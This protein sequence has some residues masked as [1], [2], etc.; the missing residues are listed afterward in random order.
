MLLAIVA[1]TGR[2]VGIDSTFVARKACGGHRGDWGT[3]RVESRRVIATRHMVVKIHM[4][5]E[6]W[7]GTWEDLTRLQFNPGFQ[8]L[9]TFLSC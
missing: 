3:G 2:V 9:A 6:T 7:N 4:H 8:R 5:L 1:R